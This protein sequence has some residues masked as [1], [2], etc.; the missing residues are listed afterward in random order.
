LLYRGLT[1]NY[2]VV[3]IV[4]VFIGNRSSVKVIVGI[5]KDHFFQTKISSLYYYAI[6][7]HST[8][9]IPTQNLFSFFIATQLWQLKSFY[10]FLT[11][12][13]MIAFVYVKY[14]NVK[15][16]NTDQIY[17]VCVCVVI[18]PIDT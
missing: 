16:Q 17:C 2:R 6:H 3:S 13:I 11:D 12:Y 7:I 15:E 14:M 18:L 10:L 9:Y 8:E 4:C 5:S 1:Y